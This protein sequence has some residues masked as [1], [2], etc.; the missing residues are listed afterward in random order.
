MMYHNNTKPSG[1]IVNGITPVSDAFLCVPHICSGL[2]F[3]NE[4]YCCP[5][6]YIVRE[7][8]QNQKETSSPPVLKLYIVRYLCHFVKRGN[9]M[10]PFL[11]YRFYLLTDDLLSLQRIHTGEKPFKCE[12]C[13]RAF[14]QPGKSYSSQAYSHHR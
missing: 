11:Y 10:S 8:I 3:F 4:F 5:I 14:R 1:K 2:F 13:G 12:L 6:R 9:S 7:E